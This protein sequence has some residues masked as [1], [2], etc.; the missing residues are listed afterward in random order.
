MFGKKAYLFYLLMVVFFVGCENKIQDVQSFRKQVN[1]REEAKNIESYLSQAGKVKAKLTAPV[2]WRY[3]LDTP[4][5][6]FPNSLHVDFY[7]DTTAVES[8]LDA[9][10]GNYLE[11]QNLVYL[12][13]SVRVV[14]RKGDSLWCKDLYWDQTT[15]KFHTDKIASAHMANDAQYIIGTNGFFADQNFNN[16]TFFEIRRS[17]INIPDSTQ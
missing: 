12:K 10:Y 4:K 15:G 17:Y 9:L 5:V 16:I 6:E 13:D 3:Q 7:D 8:K 11:N 2:M 1:G 14:T